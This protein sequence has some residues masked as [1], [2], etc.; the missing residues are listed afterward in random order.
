MRHNYTIDNNTFA[1]NPGNAELNKWTWFCHNKVIVSLLSLF[2]VCSIIA[3]IIVNNAF[4]L[5]AIVAIVI[6]IFYWTR[7]KEHFLSGASN[8]GVII[9]TN[10]TLIAVNTDLSKGFGNYPV[11]KIIESD[12]LK[13]L[14]IGDRVPTVAL[15]TASNDISLP[16]WIDFN[17]IPLSYATGSSKVITLAIKSY[18]PER[19]E[20]LERQ[21][22]AVKKPYKPGLYKVD[23]EQSDWNELTNTLL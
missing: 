21:L 11:I 22:L 3:V 7:I 12:S 10:P 4:S 5:L 9:G 18:S 14:S 2:L 23:K 17:P 19:W 15:Y 16:H 20:Q 13:H 6:N 8:S 1:S